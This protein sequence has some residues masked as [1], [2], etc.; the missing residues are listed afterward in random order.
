MKKFNW[1]MNII[2]LINESNYNIASS[3]PKLRGCPIAYT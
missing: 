1:K 3:G 2:K